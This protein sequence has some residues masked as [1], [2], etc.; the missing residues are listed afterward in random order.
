MREPRPGSLPPGDR[1]TLKDALRLAKQATNGWA[2]Y[3]R[4]KL[5][6]REIARL[7]QDIDALAALAAPRAQEKEQHE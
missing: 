2:C 1:E 3:A 4:T 7:H 5:E 6:H